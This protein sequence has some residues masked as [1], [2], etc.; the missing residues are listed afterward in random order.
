MSTSTQQQSG[1]PG[2]VN[3]S[4]H[5]VFSPLSSCGVGNLILSA[6]RCTTAVANLLTALFD[7]DFEMRKT[8]S[9]LDLCDSPP[10]NRSHHATTMGLIIG[11]TPRVVLLLFASFTGKSSELTKISNYS[12]VM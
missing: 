11:S 6:S 8:S 4:D 9:S 12:L 2:A 1:L 7:D 10:R 5:L 3:I